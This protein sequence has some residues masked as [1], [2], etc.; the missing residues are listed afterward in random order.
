VRKGL[1]RAALRYGA[2]SK[3]GPIAQGRFGHSLSVLDDGSVL[4]VG[5]R[6]KTGDVLSTVERS[7]AA[8]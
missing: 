4:V 6:G 5:G 1:K 3:I 7:N 8:P 2:W